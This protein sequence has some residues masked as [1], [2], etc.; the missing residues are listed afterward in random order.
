MYI[1][2]QMNTKQ[3]IQE[4]YEKTILEP[5]VEAQ[6]YGTALKLLQWYSKKQKMIYGTAYA[7]RDKKMNKEAEML[8]TK[9]GDADKA[10][11]NLVDK[12]KSVKILEAEI[13]NQIHKK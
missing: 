11:E 1:G 7:A 12:L 10:L 5:I 4:A 2:G 3:R 13:Y 9:L 6:T 8:I